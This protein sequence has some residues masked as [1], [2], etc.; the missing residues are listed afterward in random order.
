[1][2]NILISVLWWI[3]WFPYYGEYFDFRPMVNIFGKGL[4]LI[5]AKWW[6]TVIINIYK[7]I[8]RTENLWK[9]AFRGI[10]YRNNFMLKTLD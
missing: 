1:M 9:L 6:L 8:T 10:I 7:N 2:V 5:S 4:T 3:F